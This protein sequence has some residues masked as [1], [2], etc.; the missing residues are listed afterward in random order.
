MQAPLRLTLIHPN[1]PTIQAYFARWYGHPVLDVVQ[2]STLEQ[3]LA[4]L[5]PLEPADL[6]LVYLPDDPHPFV[7]QGFQTL[8]TIKSRNPFI[9][10]V[11]ISEARQMDRLLQSL[12]N[13]VSGYLYADEPMDR[14]IQVMQLIHSGKCVLPDEAAQHLFQTIIPKRKHPTQ[15]LS[16]RE[17]EIYTLLQHNL[18]YD[19]IATRL[20]IRLGTVKTHV[21]HI[22]S[23]LGVIGRKKSSF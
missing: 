17:Q 2:T 8:F 11:V 6:I 7:Q 15:S 4:T 9:R 22:H 5:F 10:S 13:G 23:K 20:N 18:S 19:A 3:P 1:Q 21:Y 16:K 12:V 14:I